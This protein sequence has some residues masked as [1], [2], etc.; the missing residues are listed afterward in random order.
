MTKYDSPNV[1]C[2]LGMAFQTLYSQLADALATEGLDITVPE[3]MILRLLYCKEGQQQCELAS[4]LGKD[5]GAISRCVKVMESKGLV[6]TECVSR[7]CLRV[8]LTDHGHR[9]RADV[10]RVAEMRHK[11]LA[12]ILNPKEMETLVILLKNIINN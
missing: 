7:K 9:I 4:S 3:Y 10:M 8:F 6:R 11:E 1:G 2:L 12:T 5:K